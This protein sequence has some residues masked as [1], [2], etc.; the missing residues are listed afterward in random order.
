MPGAG[1]GVCVGCG[2][3]AAFG[4]DAFIGGGGGGGGTGDDFC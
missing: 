2:V 3:G 1:G 4:D